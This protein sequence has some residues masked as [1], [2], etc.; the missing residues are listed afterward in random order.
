MLTTN[1]VTTLLGRV[2]E[3]PQV[4]HLFELIVCYL[5]LAMLPDV[6]DSSSLPRLGK[7]R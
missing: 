3:L 4:R 6:K 1:R 5:W 2:T 7:P